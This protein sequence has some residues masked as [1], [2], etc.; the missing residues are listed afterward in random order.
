MKSFDEHWAETVAANSDF[1]DPE[2]RFSI[3]VAEFRRICRMYFDKGKR[4][5]VSIGPSLFEQIFG[6]T[7]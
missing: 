1:A 2:N 3:N 5:A 6:G 7:R 4:E